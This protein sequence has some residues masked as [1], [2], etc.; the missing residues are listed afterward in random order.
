[1][2]V[3][4]YSGGDITSSDRVRSGTLASDEFPGEVVMTRE[5]LRNT[6]AAIEIMKV[7]FKADPVASGP[8]IIEVAERVGTE[9]LLTGYNNLTAILTKSIADAAGQDNLAVIDAIEKM[10][11]AIKIS[12]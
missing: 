12:E 9:G 5:Q 10:V 7:Y 3:P 6:L 8:K 11:N 4:K 1:M 2:F